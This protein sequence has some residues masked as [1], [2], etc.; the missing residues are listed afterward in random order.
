[1]RWPRTKL[2]QIPEGIQ[3][4]IDK[5]PVGPY[6]AVVGVAAVRLARIE[7]AAKPLR[8]S[9]LQGIMNAFLG[10]AVDAAWRNRG[11]AEGAMGWR[12]QL[13]FGTYPSQGTPADAF[14]A[15]L[16]MLGR[17]EGGEPVASLADLRA[18]GVH[19]ACGIG[20]GPCVCSSFGG[21]HR[22]FSM[23]AG[24]AC[25]RAHALCGLAEAD[26]VLVDEATLAALRESEPSWASGLRSHGGGG[27]GAYRL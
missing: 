8:V 1:M 21:P 14:R 9:D 11:D 12:I 26:S 17:P 23:A 15:V 16:Q 3:E 13:V 20:T 24:E 25:E 18:T 10:G 4:L 19:I 2:P 22:K 5:M 6:E 27:V 7:E